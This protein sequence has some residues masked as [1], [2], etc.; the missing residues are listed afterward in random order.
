MDTVDE[1][2]T[3]DMGEVAL[4]WFPGSILLVSKLRLGNS[5]PW[6]LR[7]PVCPSSPIMPPYPV[8]PRVSN[9]ARGNHHFLWE[10]KLELPGTSVPKPELG[11]EGEWTLGTRGSRPSSLFFQPSPLTLSSRLSPLPSRPCL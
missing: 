9:E 3:V 8:H 7:L 11:N 1:V 2:D 10:G 4:S 6:K 5:L